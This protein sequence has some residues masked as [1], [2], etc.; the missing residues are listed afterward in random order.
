MPSVHCLSTLVAMMRRGRLVETE[1]AEAFCATPRQAYTRQ[2]LCHAGVTLRRG[3]ETIPIALVVTEAN[4]TEE[5]P[6]SRSMVA[7]SAWV[8]R[9]PVQWTVAQSHPEP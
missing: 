7:H 9:V 4:Q 6:A 8:R 3:I 2:F 5:S 1:E